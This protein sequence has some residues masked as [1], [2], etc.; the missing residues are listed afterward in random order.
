MQ[1]MGEWD[2]YQGKA[3]EHYR[4]LGH[5]FNHVCNTSRWRQRAGKNKYLLSS[6]EYI[7]GVLSGCI[8][9][10]WQII[11]N[12]WDGE[13]EYHLSISMARNMPLYLVQLNLDSEVSVQVLY[14]DLI[15]ERNIFQKQRDTYSGMCSR[16]LRFLMVLRDKNISAM[17]I[18]NK[19]KKEK[20]I[21]TGYLNCCKI[22]PYV[23]CVFSSVFPSAFIN[24]QPL[25]RSVKEW[26]MWTYSGSWEGPVGK[27]RSYSQREMQGRPHVTHGADGDPTLESVCTCFIIFTCSE[28]Y[29]DRC[30]I[31]TWVK[32]QQKKRTTSALGATP[33]CCARLLMWL[34]L[35][36]RPCAE[37]YLVVIICGGGI[38]N[39]VG[40]TR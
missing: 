28:A 22:S 34:K 11:S 8:L 14:S 30:G 29:L 33:R 5:F 40:L 18:V 16:N 35:R 38:T 26:Q 20:N 25:H 27:L 3:S 1:V 31:C 39:W 21:S 17:Y 4:K 37:C 36:K 15:K 2:F 23:W 6:K 13:D 12:P 32:E 24:I 10:Y 7:D 9:I 19:M